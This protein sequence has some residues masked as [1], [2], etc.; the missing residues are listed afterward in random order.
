M[1]EIVIS[2][3]L[4]LSGSFAVEHRTSHVGR[5]GYI[6]DDGMWCYNVNLVESI[7]R[8]GQKVLA[9]SK[10]EFDCLCLA[11]IIFELIDDGGGD[12]PTVGNVTICEG[13]RYDEF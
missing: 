1:L 8:L 9:D 2:L 10:K 7:Y 12:L 3:S 4:S 6:A 11:R 5:S 13:A